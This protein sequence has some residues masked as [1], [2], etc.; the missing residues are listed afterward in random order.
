MTDPRHRILAID[1]TPENLLTLGAALATEFD[2]QV[3]TSG[4]MGLALAQETAPDLI[5]LDVMMPGMDGFETCRR[6]KDDPGLRN[7]PV[8]FVTALAEVGAE[9]TGLALGAADY[10][11]KP[12]NVEIAR[13]R[14]RNLLD[15]EN[16]RKAV[17]A[18]HSQLETRLAERTLAED[19]LRRS[20]QKL[21]MLLDNAADAVFIAGTEERWTYVNAQAV[22]LLGYRREE[23]L[24]MSIYDLVPPSYRERYRQEFAKLSSC[25]KVW[26]R[27]LRLIR[28]D[29]SRIPVEMNAVQLPDGSIYGSC[30][31]I[32]KRKQAE[33]DQRIAAIAF[34]T[35]EGILVTDSAGR[36]LRVNHAFT[37]LTGY[38]A[39][40]AIGNSP[41]MLR[42]GRQDEEFYRKLWATLLADKYWEGE[43]WNRR[44]TG[45]IYP[46][47]LTITAVSR[48]D[49]KVTHY[50]AVFSDITERKATEEQ[51]HRLAF[52]DPL[53]NLPNR[54]L[55][56]DRCEQALRV[57]A[58]HMNHGALLFLDLDRF[59]TLNDTWG[60][61]VGDLLLIEV[62]RRLLASVRAEDTVA[63]MGGD[64]FVV[65]LAELSPEAPV[66]T[67][68]AREV[69]EKIRAAINAPYSLNGLAHNSSPSIGICLFDS[70]ETPVKEL[71][72]HADQAMYHAKAAGRNA[73]RVFGE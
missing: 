45:E 19:A 69:G 55:L 73:V 41:A 70:N 71:L 20:E 28:K 14:I 50:V 66:A 5:L 16:F 24:G 62:A 40:E 27:E 35:Q 31:N 65:L 34:E 48:P 63:R 8:I 9:S 15:R 4:A 67:A 21:R 29:G 59:K 68:Q 22:A 32:S 56:Y 51:I 58:R 7:V 1:D 43:V 64:E 38:S 60:H 61:D 25:D 10:I 33:E 2:L 46:Q 17:E 37:K 26:A 6:L 23:L 72:M 13:Q 12:I 54:R 52:C 3:A 18:Q 44:K 11:T 53:T 42:S 39:K 36:I 30:R 47:W 49:G 57:C